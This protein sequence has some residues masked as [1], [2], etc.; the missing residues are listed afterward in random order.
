M[1]QGRGEIAGAT[2]S[3]SSYESGSKVFVSAHP[4]GD[5]TQIRIGVSHRSRL[6]ISIALVMPG[7]MVM[8]NVALAVAAEVGHPAAPYVALGS[9]TAIIVGLMWRSIRKSV[10]RTLGTLDNL[11][12][13]LSSFVRDERAS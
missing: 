8:V 9:G 3:Y 2:M 4:E 12:D 1:T 5:G 10:Q 13:A 11:V 6:I 7:A